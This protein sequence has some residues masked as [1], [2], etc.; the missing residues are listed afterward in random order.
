MNQILEE[1]RAALWS[2]W[3]R[4]WL[5]LGVAWGVCLL[6][7]LA[8]AMIPNS[9]ESKSRLFVQLDD[10]LANQIGLGAG[11]RQKDIERVRQTL[12]SSV[13]LEKVIRSTRIGDTI[14]T[15][16]QMERAVEDLSRDITVV[17]DA[18]NVFE[19]TAISGRRDLSDAEN[20]QLAQEI[21]QHMI[22]IFREENLGS[23]RGEMRSALDFLDQQL[24]Q[25]EKELEDAE[26]RRLA[27]EAQYPDLIGG[28]SSISAQL[29]A[30]RAELRSVEAD[31]AAAQSAMAALDGQLASTPR[32]LVTPGS[33]GPRATLAQAQSNL[34][35]MKA[36]GLT[37]SHPDVVA[38]KKQI[39]SLQQQ[40]AEG[41]APSGTPNP[42]YASL[43]A[44]LV[45][46]RANVQALQSRA[47]A[48][49]AEIASISANRAEEP[50]V[51]A[52]AQRISRDYD[53]L[54]KKYDELL[55]EREDLRLRGQV[56]TEHNAVQFEVVDPPSTP[57]VPASPN[58]PLLLL[59][60]LVVG[61]G[62]GA[63][64]AF[65]LGQLNSTFATASKLVRAIDLPVIGTI[66]LTMTDAARALRRKRLK[67]FAAGVGGL[68][69][70][71]V[72]LLGVEFVQRG[73][74][75]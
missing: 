63:G 22:D 28:A 1:A 50:A 43:Q 53:V 73:M 14:T 30:S 16:A 20:A 8:I 18:D 58:R 52:E 10:V 49:R 51:A 45:E 70:L 3:N 64:A 54:R 56:E 41:A 36:R 55:Q 39:A 9:Y 33:G 66:S 60:V 75:A 23:T 24:A 2:V 44:M 42:A 48:L 25:R 4:R 40:V 59:G 32:T 11:G 72:V 13:N 61:I 65:A 67:L 37:D 7:W 15:P 62:A 34:A 6:G 21:A 29:S 57:R 26:Q 46:R 47:A 19:I 38:L 35:S 68:G 12:T 17:G 27:F 5:A 74:V 71:F 31:L 69:L